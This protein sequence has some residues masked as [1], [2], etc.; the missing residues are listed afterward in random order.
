MP[1]RRAPAEDEVEDGG[2]DGGGDEVVE[3]LV[4]FNSSHL[5]PTWT[6]SSVSAS[7]QGTQPTAV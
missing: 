4:R 7:T 6:P 2:D 5:E 3:E 1:T